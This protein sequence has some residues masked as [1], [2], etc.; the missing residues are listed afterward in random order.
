LYL[1]TQISCFIIGQD[2]I[3]DESWQ[4][5]LDTLNEKGL[6]EFLAIWENYLDS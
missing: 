6:Q 4:A 1:D 3:T 2:E 5:F